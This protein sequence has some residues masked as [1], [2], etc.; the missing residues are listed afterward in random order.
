MAIIFYD[1]LIVKTRIHSLLDN[2]DAPENRKGKVIQLIDD[3]LL[4]G[5]I[6]LILEKLHPRHHNTFLSTVHD[7][8]YDPEI[9]SYLKSHDCP[10]IEEEIRTEADRLVEMIIEDLQSSRQL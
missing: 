9:I 4:Q 8:P 5:I 2:H 10:N 7:R 6:S 1:H 3:I